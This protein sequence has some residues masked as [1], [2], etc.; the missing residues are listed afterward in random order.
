MHQLVDLLNSAHERTGGLPNPRPPGT[1]QRRCWIN[2]N[3]TSSLA[4]FIVHM[5]TPV[6]L[7]YNLSAQCRGSWNKLPC[8][9]GMCFGKHTG[10]KPA[11]RSLCLPLPWPRCNTYRFMQHQTDAQLKYD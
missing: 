9:T 7:M 4:F 2:V 1:M 5:N 8:R 6:S 3:C 11:A 10:L